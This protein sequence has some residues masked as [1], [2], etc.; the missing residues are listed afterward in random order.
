MIVVLMGV[1]AS[2]K[3]TVG[4]QLA[5]RMGSEFADADDFH[6]ATNKQKMA[7]GHPLN[8]TDR[9]PWL[10]AL[11]GKLREWQAAGS[12]GVLACSALKV[13][14][15]GTLSAGMQPSELRFVLLDVP[16]ETLEE[17][18][19]NRKHSFMNPGLLD[20]QIATLERP[21]E[22]AVTVCNDREVDLV[23]EEILGKLS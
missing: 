16:R 21:G 13:S 7:S 22:G 8:D 11:N 1:T 19:A 2:G 20:S 15:R 5:E 18:L 17:R 12:S 9:A 14:Y 3:T 23:V 4:R 10:T 6:S